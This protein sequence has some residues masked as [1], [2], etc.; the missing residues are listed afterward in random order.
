MRD[1]AQHTFWLER[2][3]L[4]GYVHAASAAAPACS[5]GCSPEL[6]NRSHEA[7]AS[8]MAQA[9]AAAA[10]ACGAW[11]TPLAFPASHAPRAPAGI[12]TEGCSPMPAAPHAI[13]TIALPSQAWAHLQPVAHLVL[14]GYALFA[15]KLKS[16]Q[17]VAGMAWIAASGPI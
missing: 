8:Q 15:A 7:Q 12:A 14:Y 5:L 3:P 13:P 17:L 1:Y 6:Y 2:V 11:S 9:A 4:I 10:V 16:L